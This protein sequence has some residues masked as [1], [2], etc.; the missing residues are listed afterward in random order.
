MTIAQRLKQLGELTKEAPKEV[1][2][3]LQKVTHKYEFKQ[4]FAMI[5]TFEGQNVVTVEN[6]TM[7]DKPLD[8]II[9]YFAQAKVLYTSAVLHNR[10]AGRKPK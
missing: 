1:L 5:Y 3:G 6:S 9:K 10:W 4:T 7:G 2:R 8:R